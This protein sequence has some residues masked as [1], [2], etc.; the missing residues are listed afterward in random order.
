MRR[1]LWLSVVAFG[2]FAVAS[3]Y[4]VNAQVIYTPPSGG[5][6]GITI[7][8]TTITGGTASGILYNNAGVAGTSSG[9][10]LS[11]TQL[12]IPV[13]TSSAPS[14]TFT[15]HTTDGVYTSSV[16]G[17]FAPTVVAYNGGAS[18]RTINTNPSG[19]SGIEYLNNSGSAV[20]FSGYNNGSTGEFRFNNVAG[21]NR[22]IR[23]LSNSNE[24]LLV[25]DNGVAI[26][27]QA[28]TAATMTEENTA[29]LLTATSSY[30]WSNAQLVTALG[31][32][33]TGDIKVAT[34]PAKTQVNDALV[35]I[36]GAASGPPSLTVACGRTSAAYIDYIV[37]S[38]AEA[39]ANTVYGDASG[40]RG[41]NLTGYDL[42]SYTGTTDVYCHF[43]AGDTTAVTGSSGRVILKT[44][45]VP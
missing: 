23:F 8:T 5:S 10:L 31:G 7:G 9:L 21:S 6:S 2:L 40:E 29:R 1:V 14:V 41:T 15:G 24:R 25:D 19:Y 45:L 34:L 39:A 27:G 33:T 42:P 28:L 26:A 35:V 12:T 3:D 36:T 17:I 18:M 16:G 4:R 38:D 22:R 37:A 43:I 44:T 11:D 13:G 30:T 32:G 20:V